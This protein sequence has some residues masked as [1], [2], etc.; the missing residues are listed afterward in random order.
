VETTPAATPEPD[1]DQREGNA[2]ELYTSVRLDIRSLAAYR[3][4]NG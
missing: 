4:I 1:V 3:P 2:L